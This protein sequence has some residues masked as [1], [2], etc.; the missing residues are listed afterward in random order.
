MKIAI[1][2]AMLLML[3]TCGV[4]TASTAATAVALKKQEVEQGQQTMKQL[5]QNLD[6]VNQQAAQRNEQAEQSR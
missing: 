1:S 5:Q 2:V 3:A 4:D 6:Q